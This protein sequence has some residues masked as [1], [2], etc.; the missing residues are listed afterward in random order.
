MHGGASVARRMIV[1]L[2]ICASS[3]V[4]LCACSPGAD[5]A[6]FPAVHDMPAPRFEPPMNQEQVK[7]A[8]DTLMT[9]RSQLN[10]EAQSAGQSNSASPQASATGSA[11]SATKK[12]K[13]PV[14]AIQ[15]ST[16]GTTE[17][18][19]AASKP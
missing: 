7:Q 16:T 6:A 1:A 15:A 4:L 8:T 17:T 5:Y 18:A 3:A 19:G 9:E 12:K 2:A 11:A 14:P 13:K 10:A